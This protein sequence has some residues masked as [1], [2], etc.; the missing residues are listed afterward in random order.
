MCFCPWDLSEQVSFH[1]SLSGGADAVGNDEGVATA[2]KIAYKFNTN[3]ELSN[4]STDV[5]IKE[6]EEEDADAED[7]DETWMEEMAAEVTGAMVPSHDS[8]RGTQ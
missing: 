5:N 8:S 1:N 2:S 6:K 3:N 4:I 7:E